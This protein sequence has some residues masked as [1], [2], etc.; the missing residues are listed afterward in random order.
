MLV[1]I[2]GQVQ[3]DSHVM[4]T[5][6]LNSSYLGQLYRHL[7]FKMQLSLFIVSVQARN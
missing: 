1:Q 6:K 5:F 7:H 4:D 3:E 2:L